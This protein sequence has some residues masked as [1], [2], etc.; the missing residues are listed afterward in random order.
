MPDS[1]SLDI[2]SARPYLVDRTLALFGRD[3]H[4][5]EIPGR[6]CGPPATS[7]PKTIRARAP[8]KCSARR[9]K[10]GATTVLELVEGS[11]KAG[12]FLLGAAGEQAAS[13]GGPAEDLGTK[14]V[15]PGCKVVSQKMN[16]WGQGNKRS[17]T[18]S[19]VRRRTG[20]YPPARLLLP[21]G[22]E[23]VEIL[24]H[25]YRLRRSDSRFSASSNLPAAAGVFTSR[26]R[27]SR[28]VTSRP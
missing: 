16:F 6:G 21:G 8:T 20:E 26:V 5:V 17:R 18:S 19:A 25:S 24:S 3:S 7:D 28:F 22:L 2:G 23:G 12:V 4:L 15:P 27:I 1:I 9:R 13:A 11:Y 14:N 10:S